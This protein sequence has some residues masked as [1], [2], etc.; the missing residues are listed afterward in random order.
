M[1]TTKKKEFYLGSASLK[2]DSIG[3]Q[4]VYSGYIL[5]SRSYKILQCSESRAFL[6]VILE[7][8]DL[9]LS[10]ISGS[11]GRVN[12]ISEAFMFFVTAISNKKYCYD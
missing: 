3:M 6:G 4:C 7:F 5:V 11:I 9:L 1:Q 2:V 12:E 10:R 8:H